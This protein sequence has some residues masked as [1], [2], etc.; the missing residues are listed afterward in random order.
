MNKYLLFDFNVNHH[1]SNRNRCKTISDALKTNPLF[2]YPE[3]S[4]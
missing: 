2:H 3:V 1:Y 4:I